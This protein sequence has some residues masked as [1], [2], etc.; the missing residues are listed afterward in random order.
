VFPLTVLTRI[1]NSV[2][3]DDKDETKLPHVCSFVMTKK[4]AT[5]KEFQPLQQHG[6]IRVQKKNKIILWPVYFDSTKTRTEGRKIPKSYAVQ[7][8]RIEELE[9]AAQKLGIQSQTLTNAAHSKEPWRKTGLLI[10]SKED[11]KTR[12]MRRIA[13]LL[14][15]IR[16]EH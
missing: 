13:K 3:G 16:A 8:P 5:I 11:S 4:T 9:K 12:V 2:Q 1:S 10:I 7:S 15:E 6:C 14:Q